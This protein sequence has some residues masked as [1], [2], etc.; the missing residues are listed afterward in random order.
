MK[1]RVRGCLLLFMVF[2]A[3]SAVGYGA[4]LIGSDHFVARYVARTPRD[5]D[6]GIMHGAEQR[7]LIP[8][9][10]RGAVL[11]VHGFN[12]SPNNFHELP[13]Q[14]AAAGWRAKAILLPGHGTTPYDFEKVTPAHLIAAVRTALAA[15]QQ[16]H[17]TVV[18]LGHSM[19]GAI[20]T[21]AAAETPPAALILASP[22]FRVTHKWF[23]IF[24]AE[25]WANLTSPFVRWAPSVREP[26]NRPEARSQIVSY[27]WAPTR[28]ILTAIALAEAAGN[29]DLLTR[30]TCPVLL[31]HSRLDQVTDPAAATAA[32]AQMPAAVKKTT[33]LTRSDHV[34]FWD[35]ERDTVA[36]AVA[37][38]L[39]Q[40]D[41][42]TAQ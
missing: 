8:P 19:G 26:V 28:G 41:A 15:L 9:N 42:K 29:P 24:S 33:W 1:R 18:L 27:R 11:L 35:Y 23:Y 25:H 17:D 16:E 14:L 20:A 34:I 38:F 22:F 36:D 5:P 10:P 37:N 21:I 30:I 31:V 2:A 6:T 32:L 12:G 40:I 13:E 3:V 39:E 7:D 4:M